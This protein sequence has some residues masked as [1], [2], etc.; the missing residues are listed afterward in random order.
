MADSASLDL[1][2]KGTV[3]A[4]VRLDRV[5]RWSSVVAKG[6][7]NNDRSHNYALELTSSGRW[8]CVL[9]N[10]V[11]AISL[12][13]SS[14]PQAGRYYHVACVWNGTTLQL[15][16]DGA[17]NA[18]ASQSLTPAANTSPLYI[19]QFGATPTASTASSTRSG[20]TTAR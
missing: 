11:S 16:V 3:E 17:P 4:W 5:N 19:G 14:G 20:S 15:Y 10:G 18:T 7:A 12:R 8:Q 9:G 2:T 1:G 6:A 13:S